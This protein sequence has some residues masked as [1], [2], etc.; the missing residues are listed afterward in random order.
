MTC[1]LI[2]LC[3][4][5]NNVDSFTSLRD[6][7]NYPLPSRKRSVAFALFVCNLIKNRLSGI[8]WVFHYFFVSSF[9]FVNRNWWFSSTFTAVSVIICTQCMD[10][11]VWTICS[12][13]KTSAPPVLTVIQLSL[14]VR[15]LKP[16]KSRY[17][18]QWVVMF[19]QLSSCRRITFILNPSVRHS[20]NV[21]ITIAKKIFTISLKNHQ[22]LLENQSTITRLC[23][24]IKISR[25]FTP[26]ARRTAR[27]GISGPYI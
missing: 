2:Y 19:H 5:S 7:V 4:K 22:K 14:Y 15:T 27:L 12:Q 6:F 9:Y 18:F 13:I 25:W 3:I 8:N 21:T 1:R 16:S 17:S 24:Y 26:R 23:V 11:K 10:Y 20:Q